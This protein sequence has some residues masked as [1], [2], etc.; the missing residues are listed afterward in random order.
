MRRFLLFIWLLLPL[1]VTA[2]HLGPGQDQMD[3]DEAAQ[4]V[5]IAEKHAAEEDYDG[6]VAAYD[7]ALAAL[8]EEETALAREVR[9]NRAKAK[10]LT[11]LLPE[12]RAELEDLHRE[13]ED[14]GDADARVK[15]ETRA[16]LAGSQYY[17]TWLMRLEG[18]SEEEW[19]PEIEA[20][21]QNFRHLAENAEA[22]GDKVSAGAFQKDLEAAVKLA[23]MDLSDLQ[24]MP[25]PC[26]CNC[27]CSGK[28]PSQGKKKKP[29]GK[30]PKDNRGAGDVPPPD[31]VGS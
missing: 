13:L 23:R 1:G 30:K 25:L 4:Q 8:P 11:T 12:A 31:G 27:N 2:Y 29:T 24:G 15:D 19:M 10:M 21:R 22:S 5:A 20:S 17:M 28:K 6:A 7:F 16:A 18:F 26:Q 9:L 3:L 14:A